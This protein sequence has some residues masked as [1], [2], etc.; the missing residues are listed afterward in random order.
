LTGASEVAAAL[1]DES[2]V[3]LREILDDPSVPVG[4]VAASPDGL[5]IARL[6]EALDYLVTVRAGATVIGSPEAAEPL[7]A[8][9]AAVDSELAD[10]L[11]WHVTAVELVAAAEPGR[12]RNAVLGDVGRGDL[13]TMASSVPAWTW[14]DGQIPTPERPLQRAS[15]TIVTGDFPGFYDTL[16]AWDQDGGQLVAIQTNRDGL[17]WAP[18]DAAGGQAWVVTLAGA[19]VHVD[20][21]IPL[22]GNL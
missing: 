12:A 18:G 7:L 22:G 2:V 20:E 21:L 15:G 17:S 19:K 13:I 4:T 1:D 5:R 10:V 9:L 6:R 8:A 14:A 16:L 3:A 11:R